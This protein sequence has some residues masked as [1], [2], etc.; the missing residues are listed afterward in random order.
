MSLTNRRI[1]C[2]GSWKPTTLR[3]TSFSLSRLVGIASRFPR[4]RLA[5]TI[6]NNFRIGNNL[7]KGE[8]YLY[9]REHSQNEF[10]SP[11]NQMMIE[12]L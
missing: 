5:A 12:V 11:Y 8:Q 9:T 1:H 7:E 10:F 4:D 3:R 2:S 6:K